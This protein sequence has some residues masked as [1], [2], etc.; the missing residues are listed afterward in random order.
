MRNDIFGGITAAVVAL[1][2]ALAFGVASG[3]G[4]LAGLYGAIFVGFFAALL[5]GTPSQVSGPTG[6]M[7]VV[8]AGIA[9]HFPQQPECVFAVVILA[10]LLQILMGMLGLGQYIRLVPLSVTS[11][12]MTGIG[13]II[14]CTQ[15]LSLLGLSPAP[16]AWAALQRLPSALSNANAQAVGLGLASLAVALL[17][18]KR[19]TKIVPSSLLALLLGTAASFALG[20]SVP[21]L[22]PIPLGNFRP[23][24]PSITYSVLPQIGGLAITLAI[25]G[26]IDSLLTSLVADSLTASFHDSDRELVG[27]GVGNAVAGLFGGVAGAGATMRTVVNIRAGGRTPISG[28]LHSVVLL[29]VVLGLGRFAQSIPL[30]VL[31]AILLKCGLDIIDVGYLRRVPRLPRSSVLVMGVVIA[32]TVFW[33]LIVAVAAGCILSSLHFTKTMAEIE[34]DA[35]TITSSKNIKDSSPLPSLSGLW[36]AELEIVRA[37]REQVAV[38]KLRGVIAFNAANG[39]V[40]KLL[41]M[42]ESH[43]LLIIDLSDVLSVDDTGALSLAQLC[44]QAEEMGKRVYIC[45]ANRKIMRM[46]T[47]LSVIAAGKGRLSPATPRLQSLHACLADS[48]PTPLPPSSYA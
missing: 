35:C 23:S 15:S 17:T 36:P 48:T 40:R 45:G 8:T 38:A 26:A 3:M 46:F 11:G 21:V 24:I 42:V 27:Q 41:P 10:G 47:R 2:L 31:A 18:P 12:F 14:I 4:P 13:C 30:C 1:P 33:D 16:S 34:L 6:P 7:T 32:L 28:A 5:G 29:A 19:V 9:A 43:D 39:L 44:N 37:S 20:L 22:G 25:L